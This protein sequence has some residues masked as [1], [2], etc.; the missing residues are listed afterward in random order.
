MVGNWL[1]F[2]KQGDGIS[3]KTQRVRKVYDTKNVS[4]KIASRI[5]LTKNFFKIEVER[6]ADRCSTI[7]TF[8]KAMWLG[9]KV[10]NDC[11]WVN[12]QLFIEE[13]Y[14]YLIDWIRTNLVSG[15]S[16]IKGSCF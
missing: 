15:G 9:N 14:L 7:E 3:G 8:C 2:Q 1:T 4:L 16:E 13:N 10:A 6:P 12:V 11:I 5:N